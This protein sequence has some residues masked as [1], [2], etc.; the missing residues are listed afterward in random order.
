MFV[1]CQSRKRFDRIIALQGVYNKSN[2]N[3]CQT[4]QAIAMLSSVLLCE[5]ANFGLAGNLI[6][7]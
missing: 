5:Y 7:L 2:V 3:E 1:S 6:A 4:H